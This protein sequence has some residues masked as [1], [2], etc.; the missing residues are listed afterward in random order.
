MLPL[1]TLLA[2]HGQRSLAGLRLGPDAFAISRMKDAD[3]AFFD[4]PPASPRHHLS[5]STTTSLL[6]DGFLFQ[7]IT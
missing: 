7:E 2:V 5:N 3:V 1:T 4:L 6:N